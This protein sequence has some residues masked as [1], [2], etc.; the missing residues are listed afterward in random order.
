[1]TG[2]GT[3]GLEKV[4]VEA[5]GRGLPDHNILPFIE[6]RSGFKYAPQDTG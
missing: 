6:V 1:M 4:M 3:K 5:V 2:V